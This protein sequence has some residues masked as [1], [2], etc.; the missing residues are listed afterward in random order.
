[1][2]VQDREYEDEEEGREG[3]IR[4]EEWKGIIRGEEW[5]SGINGIIVLLCYLV[6]LCHIELL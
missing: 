4:G 3:I 1:M 6:L 2:N 5:I